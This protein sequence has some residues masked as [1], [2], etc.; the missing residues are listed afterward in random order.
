MSESLQ[1]FLVSGQVSL[2]E[3]M[4]MID[5]NNKGIVLVV[6]PEQRLQATITDGDVRRAILAGI[7]LDSPVQILTERRS[8]APITAPAGTLGAELLRRM[9]ERSVRQLPLVDAAG[10]VVELVT[11]DELLPTE[12]LPLEAVIMAGGAGTRLRPLTQ[13]TPKPM[14]PIGGRPMLERLIEQ[15]RGAGIHRVNIS[16]HYKREV[17]ENH[18]GDGTGFGV[19]VTY[20]KETEPLGTAGALSL[21]QAPTEPLLVV[22]GDLLTRVDFRAMMHFHREHKADLTVA[23][24]QYDVHVPFGVVETN[25]ESVTKLVEKPV[26]NFFVNAG[27][28]LLEPHIHQFIPNG[29]RYDMTELIQRLLAQ[30]R[31]VVSF[32]VLEYWLDV[33]QHADYARAQTAVEEAQTRPLNAGH[34]L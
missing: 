1:G 32:P 6:D 34:K 17:I 29:Q 20:V 16:T 13:D 5:R 25:A 15:L 28:Y 21:M 26:L 4:A 19:A 23:V 11:L 27:I 14:L 24:R 2:R 9:Q 18:F 31:R 22:N 30:Q 3:A 12:R 10:R 8:E 7:S 33:G